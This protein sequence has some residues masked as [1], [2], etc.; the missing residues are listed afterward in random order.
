MAFG[1]QA[2]T[3]QLDCEILKTE[4]LD[5]NNRS[6]LTMHSQSSNNFPNE[7]NLTKYSERSRRFDQYSQNRSNYLLN[8]SR[9]RA[10]SSNKQN[11][12]YDQRNDMS[13]SYQINETISQKNDSRSS[14]HF[15]EDGE[16]S[17]KV[18]DTM[19]DVQV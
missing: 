5:A 17:M 9:G 16:G 1:M 13:C 8:N 15:I 10:V 11:E 7:N 14:K 2:G 12:T 6:Y 4:G 19:P 18:G 3:P